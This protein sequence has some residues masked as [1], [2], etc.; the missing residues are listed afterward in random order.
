MEIV[1]GAWIHIFIQIAFAVIH[2]GTPLLS[3]R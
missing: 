2:V 1:W 3:V